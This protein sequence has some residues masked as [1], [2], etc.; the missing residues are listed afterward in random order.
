MRSC[1]INCWWR[2]FYYYFYWCVQNHE[3]TL[4]ISILRSTSEMF[5]M[6]KQNLI[7]ETGSDGASKQ[8]GF[9]MWLALCYRLFD[10]CSR[11]LRSMLGTNPPENCHLTVK[12]LTKTWHFS[13]KNWQE[14]SF[15]LKQIA[16]GNLKKKRKFLAIFFF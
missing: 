3:S 9:S 7:C 16:N 4:L 12:K 10:I 11:E 14:F 15:F 6:K 1:V 8:N 2:F 13:K 5:V